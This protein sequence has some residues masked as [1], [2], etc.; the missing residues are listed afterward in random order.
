MR[1]WEEQMIKGRGGKLQL[2][3]GSPAG[4]PLLYEMDCQICWAV[5]T[6]VLV[7]RGEHFCFF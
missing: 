3:S 7:D 1:A 4:P 2:N 5:V 6:E